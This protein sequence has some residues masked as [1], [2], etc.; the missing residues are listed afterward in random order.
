MLGPRENI[1]SWDDYFMANAVLAS[2]RSRDPN[3]QV[4]AC[5]VDEFNHIVGT[6]YN[7][8]PRGCDPHQFP[9][10]REGKFLDT[11]YAYTSHSEEN[12]IDNSDQS[13]IRGSKIYVTL[14]PCNNCAKR[15]IQNGIKEIVYLSDKYHDSDETVASR[16]LL[17][18]AGV[19]T[20]EFKFSLETITIS[21][22]NDDR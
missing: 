20:R 15:I 6:G 8:L 14:F 2:M 13:R 11:K 3:T 7:G 16:K 12:A 10:D 4:G 1:I 19:N 5:I 18:S 22:K 21:L 17:E 9:W